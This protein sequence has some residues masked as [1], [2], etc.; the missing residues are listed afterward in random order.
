MRHA[1]DKSIELLRS[2]DEY[3]ATN[4]YPAHRIM[5]RSAKDIY[6]YDVD[7][8][9]YMDFMTVVTTAVLGHN[10]PGLVEAITRVAE[11]LVAGNGYN[12]YTEELLEAARSVIGLFPG[13][14]KVLFKLS[15]SEGVELA[16]RMARSFTKGTHVFYMTGGYHGR[17]YYT[18]I[19]GG[20]R[21]NI[22]GPLP[23]GVIMIPFPNPY[24]CPFG[25]LPPEECGK[26]TVELVEHYINYAAAKDVCCLVSEP[27]LGVGGVV[28]PPRGFFEELRRRLDTYG[29]LLIMDEVQ[30]G[31]GRTGTTWAFEQFNIKP[32]IVVAAKGLTGG[33][34]ASVVVTSGEVASSLRPNDEHSTFGASPLVMAAVKASVDYYTKHRDEFLSNARAMGDY[35]VRRLRELQ[36]E[37]ELVGDVRGIGLMIGVELVRDRKTKEPA[38]RETR[39]ICFGSALR[40]GLLVTPSGLWSNVIRLAPPLTVRR[41]HVD[42]ALEILEESIREVLGAT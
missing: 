10:F 22:D 33:L 17:T 8:R 9:S 4:V 11:R 26:A 20:V 27:V 14:G 34:P 36:D 42:R 13:Y 25:E 35:M 40:R 38:S 41:E 16:V 12:W 32:D 15:G 3:V 6:V 39:E 37:Y 1:V 29:I 28:V 30:T 7:G 19:Y 2:I 23:P 18:R 24:R 5:V 31:M 21:R